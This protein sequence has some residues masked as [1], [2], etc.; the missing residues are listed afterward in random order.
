M[1]KKYLKDTAGNFSTMMAGLFFTL[2]GGVGLSV[3]YLGM[4]DSAANL[5]SA[6]DA[7]VLA[8]V[9]ADDD[10]QTAVISFA[11]ETF[12]VYRLQGQNIKAEYTFTEDSIIISAE[13]VYSPRIMGLLGFGDQK[14]STKAE[15]PF[16]GIGKL[17]IALVLDVTDSMSFDGKLAAMQSAVDGFINEFEVSKGDIRVSIVPFSQYVN[18]GVEH[19]NET[20]IDNSEEGTSFPSVTRTYTQGS[21]CPVPTVQETVTRTRDGVSFET[22]RNRCPVPRTDGVEV[23]QTFSPERVWDGCVGSRQGNKPTEPQYGGQPF[24]AVYDDGNS[25][26][27]Y[28]STDYA[29]PDALR[30]LSDD[31]AAARTMVDGLSTRGTTYMPSGLAWGWRTLDDDVPF[32][33]PIAGETRKKAI[34]LMT[35]GHNTVSRLGTDKYH[36]GK[37]NDSNSVNADA[38]AV[39]DR[40][41]DNLKSTEI[42]V[43]TIAYELPN[44]GDANATRTLLSECATTPDS[45]FDASG[46]A[47]LD[48]AFS[49]ISRDLNKIRLIN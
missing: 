34:I 30:P 39:T 42:L 17:D 15:A 11:E 49:A 41:C 27:P 36:H 13:T 12:E 23:T 47:N 3:D 5:Q 8:A 2:M 35:D 21:S 26:A 43:Y 40:I 28:W 44:G 24:L 20:W 18:V 33:R 31:L 32:G 48:A 29:C 38:N 37:A 45:F 7:A 10:D 19:R 16:G 25:A 6:V 9:L 22:T 46:G 14:L 1:F 4:T